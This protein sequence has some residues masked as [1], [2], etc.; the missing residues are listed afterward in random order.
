MGRPSGIGAWLL[1]AA[2]LI[3]LGVVWTVSLSAYGELP[4][5]IASWSSVWTGRQ[6]WVERS[7]AF[8]LYPLAQL[9]LAAV[10]LSLAEIFWLRAPEDG[11]EGLSPDPDRTRRALA[12]RREVVYLALVFVN[13]LFIHLQT[14][15][16][17]LSH[18]IGNGINRVY[19]T[20]L[21]VM[22]IFIL[23][24]YDRIRRKFL[25]ADGGS[26]QPR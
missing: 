10:A 25:R 5:D 21:I 11:R 13:L 12:L 6:A 9:V 4:R 24:P 14:S 18:R 20:A 8:F 17:L 7:W 1:L 16:I 26:P 23:G 22:I 2:N 19:F 3:L 15:R